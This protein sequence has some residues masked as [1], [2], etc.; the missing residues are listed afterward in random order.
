M[1]ETISYEDTLN[2]DRKKIYI[3]CRSPSEFELSTIPGAVNIPVLLDCERENV[4]KLYKQGDIETAKIEGI[5]AVSKRLPQIFEKIL[6]LRQDYENMFFFCARGGY[7]SSALVNLLIGIGVKSYKISGGYKSYRKYINENMPNLVENA[8]FITLYGYTGTGKTSILNELKNMGYCVIN[9]EQYANH[10]GS[11]LGSIGKSAPFSQKK[12]ESLLFEDLYKFKGKYVFV[13]G[14]SR[15]IGNIVMSSAMYQKLRS[16]TKI[17]IS[18]DIDFRVR[19]IKNQYLND[20]ENDMDLIE[21]TLLKLEKYISKE[22][23]DNYISL[24]K[25][26]KID[27]LISDLCIN[28]YDKN[29]KLPKENFVKEYKNDNSKKIAKQIAEYF[30]KLID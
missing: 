2:I 16:S 14:E 9:L 19:E 22:R 8:K 21:N 10:R 7:R 11:L 23:L 4:G 28:Y 1:F 15:R 13:E 12:F 18:S 25:K 6:K 5:T 29:Y 30:S 20:F 27:E 17:L 24:L 3:D 26:D